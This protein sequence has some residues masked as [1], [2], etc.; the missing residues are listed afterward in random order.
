MT[1]INLIPPTFLTN[2]HLI[3]EYRELPRLAKHAHRKHIK[4]PNFAPPETYRL[5]RG[6][7][8]FFVNKGKW[9]ARRH[10]ALVGEMLARGYTVNYP[11]YPS[12]VHPKSLML[13]WSPSASE[14]SIN[15]ERL[16][17]RKFGKGGKDEN[18]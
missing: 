17:D 10:R 14:V 11:D 4:N 8:D 2:S 18:R 16:N 5:G 15:L 7:V 9:L 1:R 3:A 13:D 12:D 6:H